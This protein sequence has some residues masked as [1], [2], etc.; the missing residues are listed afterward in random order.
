MA[1]KMTTGKKVAIGAGVLAIVGGILCYFY[2]PC[3]KKDGSGDGGMTTDSYTGNSGSGATPA[4]FDPAKLTSFVSNRATAT[5]Y[6]GV[7][8]RLIDV[9]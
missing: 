8:E 6:G 2:C 7:P 4:S 5:A 9:V 1:K 3:F